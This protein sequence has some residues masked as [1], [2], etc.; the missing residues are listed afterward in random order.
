MI[1]QEFHGHIGR[2]YDESEAW[3]PEPTRAPEDAPNVL[4][5]VLDDV[6][7]GQIGCYGGLIDT[8]NIDRLAENGLQYNNFHTTALCAPTR[9]CLLTGRNH[10]SN[11]M[12]TITETSTGFPGYNG[13]IPHENGFLSE[14]LVEEG[15]N[16][17]AT[18]KWHLAL[19][20]I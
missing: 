11:G 17:F 5:I 15:Y 16:T 14:M 20:R 13:H 7:F 10:H 2:T 12:G 18:G 8:P 9:S 1:D 19:P 4:M 6:G 3:W